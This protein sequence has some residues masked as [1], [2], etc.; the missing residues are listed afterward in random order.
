MKQVK[1]ISKT[2]KL[3]MIKNVIK[4]AKRYQKMNDCYG[5]CRCIKMTIFELELSYHSEIGYKF[6][7]GSLRFFKELSDTMISQG[8][9]KKNIGKSYFQFKDHWGS[10][11]KLL[12]RVQRKVEKL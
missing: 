6:M 11:I 8:N 1:Q 3:K 10:R 12:E 2:D 9:L 5:I 4:Q 7:K